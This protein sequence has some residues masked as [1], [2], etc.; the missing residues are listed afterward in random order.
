M[1]L[2]T[3]IIRILRAKTVNISSGLLKLYIVH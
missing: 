2:E 1:L 3:T